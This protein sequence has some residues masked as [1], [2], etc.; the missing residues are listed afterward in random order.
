VGVLEERTDRSPAA[1]NFVG[2]ALAT[3]GQELDRALRLVQRALESGPDNGAF[4]DSM[5]W[6]WF[7]RGDARRALQFLQRA[8]VAAPDEPTLLEHL[9][10]VLLHGGQRAEARDC[11]RRAVEQ[12]AQNPDS[13]E[14]PGQGA[15][16]ERKLKLLSPGA[17]SR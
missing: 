16:L 3:H 10:E 13:A 5:G 12:L 7:K 4:L 2:Y 1:A 17:A 15:D 8:L 11:F 9:G 6:V 14:R